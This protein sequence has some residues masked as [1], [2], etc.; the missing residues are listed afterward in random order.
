M[1][2]S[3]TNSDKQCHDTQSN[4]CLRLNGKINNNQA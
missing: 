3:K 1:Q 4:C 2:N